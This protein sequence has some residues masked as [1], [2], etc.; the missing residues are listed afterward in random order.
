MESVK[1]IFEI[2]N[3]TKIFYSVRNRSI[4]ET[5]AIDR[6]SCNID[7]GKFYCIL[8]PS[9]C[10]KSTLLQILGGLI[11]T[12]DGIV[13]FKGK[14]FKGPSTERGYIF[15]RFN[16]FPWLNSLENVM[17]GLKYQGVKR[18][19]RKDIAMKKLSIV[20][21]AK[22]KDYY[23]NE[24]S[25]GMQQRVSIARTLAVDP[26]VYLMDEPFGSLDA[27]TRTRM[28]NELVHLWQETDLHNK[29]VIFVTHDIR[30]AVLLADKIIVMT[31]RPG[32]LKSEIVIELDRPRDTFDQQYVD[33]TREVFTGMEKE[34]EAALKTEMTA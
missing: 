10:G 8:G 7:E 29:T 26:E 2:Q 31:A 14:K 19:E 1:N 12:T 28:Q 5:L 30:E 20:G 4:V 13:K 6:I 34:I 32:K 24:L 18:E 23:P 3:L 22:F 9:G 27:Q 25:G 15:Q 16:L 21:L 11:E 17:F 33:Y